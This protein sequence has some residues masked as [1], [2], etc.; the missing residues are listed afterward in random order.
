[1]GH[2]DPVYHSGHTKR[3]LAGIVIHISTEEA[4]S[5]GERKTWERV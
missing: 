5:D 2:H 3:H 1:M 4:Q